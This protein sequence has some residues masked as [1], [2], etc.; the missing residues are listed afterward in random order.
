MA[1]ELVFTGVFHS[2]NGPESRVV[3]TKT[4]DG[5]YVVIRAL[6]EVVM[7]KAFIQKT[8]DEKHTMLECMELAISWVSPGLAQG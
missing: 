8:R 4:P 3:I 6:G 7:N 2:P 5:Q 1:V